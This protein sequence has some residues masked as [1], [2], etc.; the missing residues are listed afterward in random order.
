MKFFTVYTTCPRKN[1]R[2]IA[3][4]LVTKR[5]AACANVF[6]ID[7]MYRWKGK[8]QN[9]KECGI[10]FKTSSH[11]LRSLMKALKKIHPYEVPCIVA[12]E[13]K[14]SDSSYLDWIKGETI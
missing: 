14:E 10:L 3:K 7:S 13:I 1:A 9:S 5:L 8:L 12:W 4:T 2:R 11:A 6:P